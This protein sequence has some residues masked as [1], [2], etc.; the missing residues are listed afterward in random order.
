M[1][2]TLLPVLSLLGFLCFS[3]VPV[4]TPDPKEEELTITF[5]QTKAEGITSD[6][7]T[8][9]SSVSA[10]TDR[11][12]VAYFYYGEQ[13]AALG[14]AGSQKTEEFLVKDGGEFV[15]SVSGLKEATTYFYVPAVSYGGKE[16]IGTSK[17]FSTETA[18]INPS[19]LEAVTGDA[20]DI[21]YQN[22]TITVSFKN[23]SKDKNSTV[24]LYIGDNSSIDF[25]ISS[26]DNYHESSSSASGN[27]SHKFDLSYD[28]Q[29]YYMA[30]ITVG[31]TTVYGEVKSF[32]TKKI[33]D[34]LEVITGEVTDIT[35]NS[36]T[37]KVTF[38]NDT[39]K[40]NC[41]VGVYVGTS[42]NRL[43]LA[44]GDSYYETTTS[45]FGSISL[46]VENLSEGTQYYYMAFIDIGIASIGG[47]IKSF[48]TPETSRVLIAGP[49][50]LDI[51]KATMYVGFENKTS[52]SA[53]TVGLAYSSD[54]KTIESLYNQ[55]VR[56]EVSTTYVSGTYTVNLAG[57]N[58]E[59][60]YYCVGYMIAGSDVFYSDLV[61]FKTADLRGH[62]IEY[63]TTDGN[64]YSELYLSMGEGVSFV[65]QVSANGKFYLYF[66]NPVDY[67]DQTF[68]GK[69]NLETVVVPEMCMALHTTFYGCTSLTSV[70]LP[71]SLVLLAGYTFKGCSSLESIVIPEAVTEIGPS[72]FSGCS[73]LS[74]LVIPKNVTS[75]GKLALYDCAK[76]EKL[77]MKPTTPPTL[78]PEANPSLFGSGENQY[79]HIPTIYVPAASLDAYKTA[80]AKYADF[81]VEQ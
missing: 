53:I 35:S 3:C 41:K 38:K 17:S 67:M 6:S 65:K 55:G 21:T 29:Y 47:Q 45:S 58:G 19:Q 59:T 68:D 64:P 48:T 9:K 4:E 77:I 78:D 73:S 51:R 13:E 66:N 23:N 71:E 74:E 70:T 24:G 52:S 32:T 16:Y 31:D 7:A 81:I 30:Y 49:E 5:L 43:I 25:L 46:N 20:T 79:Y 60:T 34:Y 72:E 56:N 27:I 37:I 12:L 36:A 8:L 44:Q 76:L 61:S 10:N 42:S 50:N 39:G 11:S 26:G 75:I 2:K 22:A 80:W 18:T 62:I 54:Y 15:I 1:K 28:T 63:T 14:K 40:E 69:T 33:S 57:L